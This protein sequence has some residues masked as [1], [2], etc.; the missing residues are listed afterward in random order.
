MPKRKSII[1]SLILFLGYAIFTHSLGISTDS[2][3]VNFRSVEMP[4]VNL[5]SD[6]ITDAISQFHLSTI[7]PK[8]N[9][10]VGLLE[11]GVIAN[12]TW[13]EEAKED[14]LQKLAKLDIHPQPNQE[15]GFGKHKSNWNNFLWNRDFRFQPFESPILKDFMHRETNTFEKL[16]LLAQRSQYGENYFN[17]LPLSDVF[18]DNFFAS[19]HYKLRIK[20]AL[21][22]NQLEAAI[23]DCRTF[24]LI[25]ILALNST[26]AN[27]SLNAAGHLRAVG[28]LWCEILSH[29]SICEKH[30]LELAEHFSALPSISGIGVLDIQSRLTCLSTLVFAERFGIEGYGR[31]FNGTGTSWGSKLISTNTLLAFADWNAFYKRVSRFYDQCVDILKIEDDSKRKAAIAA[32]SPTNRQELPT[33]NAGVEILFEVFALTAI[34]HLKALEHSREVNQIIKA[35][36]ALKHFHLDNQ[37]YP[38]TLEELPNNLSSQIHRDIIAGDIVKFLPLETGAIFYRIG[39]NKRDDG[40][41]GTNL[42]NT[43]FYDSYDDIVF[44]LGD[45]PRIPPKGTYRPF[46]FSTGRQHTLENGRELSFSGEEVNSQDF[47]NLANL[48]NLVWLDL[49]DAQLPEEWPTQIANVGNLQTLSLAG[50]KFRDGTFKALTNLPN[51]ET[52]NLSRS[53]F[54]GSLTS[55]RQM[56]SLRR[57][58]LAGVA[59]REEDLKTISSLK[60]V[61]EL[62]LCETTI[63]DTTIKLISTMPQLKVLHLAGT[64]ITDKGIEELSKV[65][66]LTH[67]NLDFTDITNNGLAV[68]EG[69]GIECISVTG[70]Q[71]DNRIV[72]R[73]AYF[74]RLTCLRIN[75]T[76]FSINGQGQLSSGLMDQYGNDRGVARL[77]N[78]E[79]GNST[80]PDLSK[81]LETKWGNLR[82]HPHADDPDFPKPYEIKATNDNV[83]KISLKQGTTAISTT[84]RLT[85]DFTAQ[86]KVVPDWPGHHRLMQQGLARAILSDAKDY[87]GPHLSAGL[88]VWEAEGHYLK[89][90]WNSTASYTHQQYSLIQPEYFWYNKTLAGFLNDFELQHR[91]SLVSSIPSMSILSRSPQITNDLMLFPETPT[92]A[93][94]DFYDH[95]EIWLRLKRIGNEMISQISFNGEQW[96][97]ISKKRVWFKEN[98]NVGIWC[99]KLSAA[100]YEFHFED[101][102]IKQ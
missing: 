11:A 83:F 33:R 66:Q 59:L 51:L 2:H 95:E 76:R 31:R 47:S 12:L 73:L 84:R 44:L 70:A 48:P 36:I 88:L 16:H 9:F 93:G 26:N 32:V 34:H 90:C 89:W 96:E 3:I 67:I 45:D 80:N 21:S 29:S 35:C 20:F 78:P 99:G 56:D 64:T 55:L 65:K 58:N 13:D 97:T 4:S 40:G 69:G 63:D 46:S 82:F 79:K 1:V 10:I 71:V 5:D 23:K 37:H 18:L 75:H 85:G 30:L 17:R 77:M 49:G 57:I 42:T 50:H 102:T 72:T 15:L 27:V 22:Q 25:S 38:R 100:D 6:N 43:N 68:L 14:L 28:Q 92:E 87:G 7:P 61:E 74:P 52:L 62:N 39:R 8:S 91:E 98:V 101:F 24:H 19:D 86:V 60:N 53:S 41:W 94:L 81:V 54:I